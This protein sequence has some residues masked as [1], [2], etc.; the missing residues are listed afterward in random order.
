MEFFL[1]EEGQYIGLCQTD[2]KG[3]SAIEGKALS[4][5]PAGGKSEAARFFRRI[6]KGKNRIFF[7][8]STVLSSMSPSKARDTSTPSPEREEAA[9]WRRKEGFESPL[10]K[11][12]TCSN[13]FSFI[14]IIPF[15]VKLSAGKTPIHP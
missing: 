2:A 7:A 14:S 1:L 8:L 9:F 12:Y 3:R 15:P 10:K 13:L 5:C 4:P 6:E 11:A